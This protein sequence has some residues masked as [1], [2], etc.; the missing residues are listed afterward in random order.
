MFE[1]TARSIIFGLIRPTRATDRLDLVWTERFTLE[2]TLNSATSVPVSDF[3][4]AVL[5][6]ILLYSVFGENHAVTMAFL[7]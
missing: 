4:L 1:K 5:L 7:E 6:S 2:P 3:A